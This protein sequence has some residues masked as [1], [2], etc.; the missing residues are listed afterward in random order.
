MTVGRDNCSVGTWAAVHGPVVAGAVGDLVGRRLG[1]GIGAFRFEALD[2]TQVCL[3]YCFRGSVIL[4][5]TIS[6]RIFSQFAAKILSWTF[7]S[8]KPKEI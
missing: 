1:A 2:S 4:S 5:R 6:E 3:A 8:Y 7:S